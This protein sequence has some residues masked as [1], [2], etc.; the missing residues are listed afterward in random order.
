MKAALLFLCAMLPTAAWPDVPRE[1]TPSRDCVVLLHG[2]AGAP[3]WMKR[4]ELLL[5]SEGYEV[6][7]IS[8]PSTRLPIERLA[9]EH[10]AP[11]VQRIAVPSGRQIHFVTHS[12]GGLLLRQ[13]LR[14]NRPEN[15][16][17]VVM[18][19]PPNQGSEIADW[20]EKNSFYQLVLGPSGQQL[21]TGTNDF[22]HR[23]GPVRF[24][25]G[26]IAGD[27]SFNPVFSR[28]LPGPDDGK[29]SVASTQVEGMSDFLV[30]RSSHTLLN[31][32]R[33]V[34][35]QVIAFLGTGQFHR[36]PAAATD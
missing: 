2:L 5:K 1:M 24:P 25:L 16:G 30:M 22:P 29:V 23:L 36:T 32:K 4:L 7:S 8:Y 17:R 27:L 34:I 21:G 14:E 9:R 18:L 35:D 33:P 3:V 19:G 13:Y 10:L 28:R 20:L 31:W 15:L 11:A 6:H 26:V 12:L